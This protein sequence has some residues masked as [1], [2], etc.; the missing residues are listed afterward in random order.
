[1]P[2]VP[3]VVLIT[4]TGAGRGTTDSTRMEGTGVVRGPHAPGIVPN[5]F[6]PGW[7][8]KGVEG[9]RPRT[10]GGASWGTPWRRLAKLPQLPQPLEA[11]RHAHNPREV[12]GPS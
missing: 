1:M 10:S 9:R 8:E 6:E 11:L 2:P 7:R 5:Q 4:R 12:S 3:S